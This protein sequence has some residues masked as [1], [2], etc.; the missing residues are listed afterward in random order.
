MTLDEGRWITQ[1][2]QACAG[3]SRWPVHVRFQE[4]GASR[5][6]GEGVRR[7]GRLRRCT[8]LLQDRRLSLAVE[9]AC[10]VIKN[11]ATSN[12]Q[13]PSSRA[14]S[15]RQLPSSR[16][17][18]AVGARTTANRRRAFGSQG[19]RTSDCA[20][21]PIC[22][23]HMR[24]AIGAQTGG[25]RGSRWNGI[26]GAESLDSAARPGIEMSR[27]RHWRSN[28]CLTRHEGVL[29]YGKRSDHRRSD[30]RRSGLLYSGMSL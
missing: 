28:L 29:P 4:E 9:G 13:L 3:S 8:S 2:S 10:G 19:E 12:R 24:V 17:G 15:N 11:R 23:E 25:G 27:H 20:T 30:H 7:I 1:G 5:C 6:A 22:R 18:L 26:S 16:A 21:S 14:T